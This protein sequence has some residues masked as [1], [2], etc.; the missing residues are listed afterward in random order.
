MNYCLFVELYPLYALFLISSIV[1][2]Y[3]IYRHLKRGF[4]SL[5][6]DYIKLPGFSK[7]IS[8]ILDIQMVLFV[9]SFFVTRVPMV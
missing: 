6:N 9:F 4:L 8:V 5:V 1:S 7:E 2:F 3:L